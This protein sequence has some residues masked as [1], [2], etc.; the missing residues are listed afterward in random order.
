VALYDRIGQGYDRTRRADPAIAETLARL[1]EPMPGRRYLDL[2]CG[3]GNYTRALADRGG[4]W[5]GID[6]S[7]TMLDAARLQP[8]GITWRLADVSALPFDD[9]AFDGVLCTLAIHH[10]ADREAAFREVR[11]VVGSGPFVLFTC[12]AARTGR[13][14][15]RAYFPEMFERIALKEPREAE[16]LRDLRAA[17]FERIETEPYEVTDELED[18]F[19]YAGKRRPELYFDPA[20]RRAISSF[21]NLATPAEVEAGLVR[22]RADLDAGHFESV[23]AEHPSEGGDY[24]F[25][26]ARA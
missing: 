23:S 21:A 11:R 7:R 22:L 15:L 10:F 9:Q 24:L 18:L 19:L 1:L 16:I 6:A 12:E 26:T 13:Y 14:W 25:V 2:A 8:D 20:L 5:T 3:T 17:G 4:E